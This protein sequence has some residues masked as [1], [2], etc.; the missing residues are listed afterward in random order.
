MIK[1][2]AEIDIPPLLRGEIW[3]AL[4]NIRGDFER[5][6]LR[7]DKETPTVTDRQVDDTSCNL[8]LYKPFIVFTRCR[9]KWIFQDV[10]N[11]MSC[12]HQRKA[13]KS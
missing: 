5:E 9:L 12:F 6:Y 11:T 13:I 1:K 3:A 8:L 10:I 2:Q 7:I 4:L